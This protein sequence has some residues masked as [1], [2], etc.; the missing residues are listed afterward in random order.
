M[1][2]RRLAQ[3]RPIQTGEALTEMPF[4]LQGIDVSTEYELQPAVTT[5]T[6]LNVRGYEPGTMRAR[7]GSRP[8]ILQYV[9]QQGPAGA[10]PLQPL[11]YVVDPT[12]DAPL[13]GVDPPDGG[14][15]GGQADPSTNNPADP[16][17]PR[18]PAPGRYVRTGGS[19]ISLNRHRFTGH[20]P[21]GGIL[22]RSARVNSAAA[23]ALAQVTASFGSPTLAGSLLVVGV[24]TN[25]DTT[26]AISDAAA[27]IW[28]QAGS[29]VS[30]SL[31]GI[32]AKLSLWYATSKTAGT[33]QITL[34]YGAACNSASTTLEY[35]RAKSGTL[36]LDIVA[37]A[38][39]A[40]GHVDHSTHYIGI[41]G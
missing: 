12:Q 4:P 19:G 28:Q 20:K 9:P 27:N 39:N 13:T 23:P 29:Y 10:H 40:A 1:D 15:A 14:G 38:V 26:V 17:G 33:T 7:G 37:A 34:T 41:T 11:N 3:R 36:V 18:N 30:M 22:W 31:F 16:F 2:K 24:C 6:G 21:L 5:P 35:T 8:G 32:N 25:V